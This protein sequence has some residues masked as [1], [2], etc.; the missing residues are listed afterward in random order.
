MSIRAETLF[1][2]YDKTAD[3]V[4]ANQF[5]T[6]AFQA[7]QTMFEDKR[8]KADAHIMVYG[9]Y[10]AGKSTLIN[11]LLGQEQAEIDDVPKTDS[12]TAYRWGQYDILDTP[13]VDAPIEHQK[14]TDGEMLKADAVI[15]VV[16]PVGAAEE[17]NTLSKLLELVQ[18]R[19][20]VF[21]VFNEK[22]TLEMEDFQRLKDQTQQR[23]QDLAA[24]KG[25][26]NVLKDIPIVRVNAK[27]AFK[28]K[29]ENKSNLLEKSGFPEFEKR[30]NEFLQSISL[31]HIYGRLKTALVTFLAD[32]LQ[33]LQMRSQAN[34]VKKYDDLLKNIENN[35][36]QVRRNVRQAIGNERGSIERNVA[37][38]LR[39]S[40]FDGQSAQ[41]DTDSQI[42][43]AFQYGAEKVSDVLQM[44]MS[45]LVQQL[46]L[47]IDDLQAQIPQNQIA[48]ESVN[49]SDLNYGNVQ[50]AVDGSQLGAQSVSQI[51]PDVVAAA[52]GQLSQIAKPEHIV[53]SLQLVKEY[54]PSLMKGVGIK[55]MEKWAG[56]FMSKLPYVGLVISGLFAL[57]DIFGGDSEAAQMQQQI[58]EQNRQRERAMQQIADAARDVASQFENIMREQTEKTIEE[59]FANIMQ[60]V[61]AL[62][63]GFSDSERKNS[64]W[65]EQLSQYHALAENA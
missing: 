8:Q 43:Q 28:G 31:D 18:A 26:N 2:A 19:K 63:Q 65:I 44:E 37:N 54:I 57:K 33:S 4:Q 49:L 20:Q 45:A 16:N 15:F 10:N 7:I 36:N 27:S 35:K 12:V 60:Q 11:A 34:M 29:T 14:I 51:S 64:E 38:Q 1:Q 47:D 42:Q 46:Q 9:V 13:G 40:V 5:E 39:K 50:A 59:T 41:G 52:V 6:T 58:E 22:Q 30:L 55:T 56:A 17:K 23:L 62:R 21:L 53:K 61:H 48:V 3:F 32:G 25:L 24:A